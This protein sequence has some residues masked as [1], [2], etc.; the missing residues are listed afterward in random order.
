MVE[1]RRL[2]EQVDFQT[3]AIRCV[4]NYGAAVALST[5]MVAFWIG[6]LATALVLSLTA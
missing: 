6:A 3:L 5:P 2:I 4:D 1:A